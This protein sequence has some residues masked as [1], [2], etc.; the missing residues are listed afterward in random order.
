[1]IGLAARLAAAAGRGRAANE[2]AAAL[3]AET[4]LLFVRDPQLGVLI[5][6]PGF[7]Q[8][9][10]GGA[11][12]RAFLESCSRPGRCEGEVDVP[13]GTR[14]HA[15]A[16]VQ[17]DIAAVLIGGRLLE[18][19]LLD[20]KPVM[21]LLAAVF[22]A[23]QQASFAIAQAADARKTASRAHGLAAALETARAQA[24]EINA[25]LS[26]QQR[27]KDE[28]LA[29]LSHELRNPLAPIRNALT[30]L[31]EAGGEAP[32]RAQAEAI[33]DR[34][35]SHMIRLVDDLLDVSRISRGNIALKKQNVGLAVIV[36]A[37]V[38]TSRPLVDAGGHTMTISVPQAP[39]VLFADPVRLTQVIANLLNNAA[40]YT[41]HGGRIELA[42]RTEPDAALI[43]VRDNGI[44]I[45]P[46]LLPGIFEMFAQLDSARRHAPG[47]LGIGLALARKLVELHGGTLE[48]RSEGPGAGSEFTMRIPVLA[49][50]ASRP[51]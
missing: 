4:F 41:P 10:R 31:R 39:I 22:G 26:E 20:F 50:Q 28:F 46:G 35:V 24:A 3:G 30:L 27:R 2:I 49:A 6:A 16:L 9:V 25:A 15:V 12:W 44:G 19:G 21:P 14:R 51:A 32:V 37:A 42:A 38:E 23:E 33:L 11:A 13:P 48:G 7:P 5:P 40:K 34:Q 29:M 1:M 47:G 17:D 36:E 8:T 18:G 43:C 45:S